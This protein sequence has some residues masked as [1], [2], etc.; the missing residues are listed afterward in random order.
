MILHIVGVIEEFS[1]PFARKKITYQTRQRPIL[2]RINPP[3]TV[4]DIIEQNK[5]EIDAVSAVINLVERVP[6]Q[7]F[8]YSRIARMS[9]DQ[10]KNIMISDHSNMPVVT[11]EGQS[12]PMS[13]SKRSESNTPVV[14]AED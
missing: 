12:K 14:S 10:L 4:L 3:M 6:N 11:Q 8:R 7:Q 2:A 1:V 5:N 9:A 13:P